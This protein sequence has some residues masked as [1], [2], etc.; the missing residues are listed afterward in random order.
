MICAGWLDVD[1]SQLPVY[2]AEK[3]KIKRPLKE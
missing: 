2:R 1:E 3:S